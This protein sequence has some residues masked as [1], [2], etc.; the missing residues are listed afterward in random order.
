MRKKALLML[1]VIIFV[2]GLTN[3]AFAGCGCG[4][5]CNGNCTSGGCGA[6]CAQQ[7]DA[8]MCPG[9]DLT[10]AN[11]G[12]ATASASKAVNVG[13]KICPV[14]GGKIDDKHA[15][16]YEYEGKIYNFCC[17]ECIEEFKKDPQ[18]YIHKV[19]EE[20]NSSARS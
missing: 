13:N 16:T 12:V 10:K 20:L 1:G 17:P 6:S 9:H 8:Q 2:V 15:I 5:A 4:G 7:K 11:T 14:M 3:V 19:D 18:K